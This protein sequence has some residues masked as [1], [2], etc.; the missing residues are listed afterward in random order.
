MEETG[1]IQRILWRC[2]AHQPWNRSNLL[3]DRGNNWQ[4]L[5]LE[6]KQLSQCHLWSGRKW[7]KKV[8]PKGQNLKWP[9]ITP[10]HPLLSPFWSVCTPGHLSKILGSLPVQHKLPVMWKII[11]CAI[12]PA[13]E[14]SQ[15]REACSEG[16]VV[17]E[18]QSRAAPSRGGHFLLLY[19]NWD[20]YLFVC[21][22]CWFRER[23]NYQDSG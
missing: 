18:D 5:C 20:P 16:T 19:Q 23:S 9:I 1:R 8:Q 22:S 17:W 7:V 3:S 14:R 13:S 4:K 6:G 12:D 2:W 10:S 11:C 21:W 15:A